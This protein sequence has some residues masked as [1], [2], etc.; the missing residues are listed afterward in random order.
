MVLLRVMIYATLELLYMLK[1]IGPR[2]SVPQAAV[3]GG[4]ADVNHR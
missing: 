4:V 2:V 3:A 1:L